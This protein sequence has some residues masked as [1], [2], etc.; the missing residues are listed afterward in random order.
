[1]IRN[2]RWCLFLLRFLQNGP[3]RVVAVHRVLLD[4]RRLADADD[5][6]RVRAFTRLQQGFV[7][8]AGGSRGRVRR[9]KLRNGFADRC[10]S[11]SRVENGRWAE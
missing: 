7:L 11:L 6:F 9:Q 10:E 3:V 4:R 5:Y 8:L 2:G 1:M